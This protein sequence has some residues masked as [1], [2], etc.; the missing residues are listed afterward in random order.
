MKNKKQDLSFN[1]AVIRKRRMDNNWSLEYFGE[2]INMDGGHLG[3]IERGQ[4]QPRIYTIMKI[5]SALDIPPSEVI[6]R[7]PGND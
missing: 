5:C 6:W 3:K 1:A 4:K 2:L 7:E